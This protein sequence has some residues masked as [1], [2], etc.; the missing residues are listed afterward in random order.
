MRSYKWDN[1]ND[2]ANIAIEARANMFAWG[3]MAGTS[4][5]LT[6]QLIDHLRSQGI[7]VLNR[8]A[9]EEFLKSHDL[10]DLQQAIGGFISKSS[11]P[12]GEL[13]VL[14]SALMSKFGNKTSY[15]EIIHTANYE[16]FVNYK[17]A[18][19]FDIIDYWKIDNGI[20][21]Y[22]NADRGPKTFDRLSERNET[23]PRRSNGDN[24]DVGDR[25]TDRYY[26]PLDRETSQ[27]K[28]SSQEGISS[29]SQNLNRGFI[30]TG[31]DGTNHPRYVRDNDIETFTTPQG[32][33]YGFVD[34]DG[35]IYL[36]ET[37]ISPEH[38]IHEYTHLWD[39]AV[40]ERNPKLWKRGIELMKQIPLW[41]EI[42]NSENYGKL[43]QSQGI[44]GE[45]LENLIAS[46][47]H[48]RLVGENG[49]QLLDR[50]AKEKGQSG[51][52]SKLKQW[53]LDF[54]KELKATFG[55]WS[56]EELDNL[57]LDDFSKMTIRDFTEGTVLQQDLSETEANNE[58]PETS[59]TP[60]VL[61]ESPRAILAREMSVREIQNRTSMMARDFSDIVSIELSDAIERKQEELAAEKD[62]E[63]QLINQ[64]LLIMLIGNMMKA[65][66]KELQALLQ[67]NNRQEMEDYLMTHRAESREEAELVEKLLEREY[68]LRKNL[69][70]E[71]KKTEKLLKNSQRNRA[72]G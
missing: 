54:W 63:R 46:E 11:L 44:T 64:Y 39:R 2:P 59:N 48:A 6:S 67:S 45:R 30:K 52:I 42:A 9:M 14:Q 41:Q 3:Q 61:Q 29:G 5:S 50:I 49:E 34:K 32:E 21:A 47:V 65:T 28:S 51:I 8:A 66:I 36:D 12:K 27:G 43:W 72:N 38:P 35:N 60:I 33:V 70:T 15:G 56:K 19:E 68:S 57:A 18:G 71:T 7:K 25:D 1:M 37:V 24:F 16:Y 26:A 69:T 40:Q 58:L 17:G 23:V 62:A 53:I 22:K 13:S 20:N 10:Q 4:P 55:S 31:Y